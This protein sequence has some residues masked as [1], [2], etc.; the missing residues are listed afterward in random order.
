MRTLR[1]LGGAGLL[2]GGCETRQPAATIAQPTVI[3]AA[4][5]SRPAP[6]RTDTA[7]CTRAT[8]PRVPG[9]ADTLIAIGTRHY[10]LS[11][12]VSTDSTHALEYG[13]AA[14]AGPAFAV[15]SDSAGNAAGRVRGYVETYAFVLRDS[16]RRK[17]LFSRLLHKPDFYG[18]APHD[19]VTVMNLPRPTYLGYS[20]GLDA[21]VFVC[22]LWVP[23]SD[24]GERVTL[25]L[26]RQGRVKAL[27]PSG[28][29]TWEAIDCDPQ[30]APNGRA[31]LT[32]TELLRAGQPSLKLEKP[33][34]LLRAAR[35][36]NDT[37]LLVVYENGDYRPQ[38]Q[39]G[40]ASTNAAVTAPLAEV[41]FVT[42]P[43]QRRL[44]TA[45]VLHTNGRVMRRFYLATTGVA[46]AELPRAFVPA[47]G[48]YFLYDETAR[49]LVLLPKAQPERFSELPLKGLSTFK[50]PRRPHETRV[51]I[52]SEFSHLTLYVDTL[53]PQ[54]VRYLLRTAREG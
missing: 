26:D 54:S 32:C 14:N 12:R 15:A 48:T 46:A 8:A 11:V 34:A 31:V 1:I 30:L 47:A 19:I 13:R 2:L 53:H 24:V 25:A 41:E 49:K 33:H 44:P 39:Q 51:D 27:S 20:A 22:Y 18:V 52:N 7:D 21:L 23:A 10:W 43:A 5:A 37:T 17:M 42:T 9:S 35:F 28:P 50:L 38:P 29:I 4:P 6:L 16:S 40:R 3:A 45:F 36:L